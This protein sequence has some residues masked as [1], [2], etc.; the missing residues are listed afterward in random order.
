MN[1]FFGNAQSVL[2]KSY[3]VETLFDKGLV[4]STPAELRGFGFEK[5]AVSEL[6]SYE[7]AKDIGKLLLSNTNIDEVYYDACF[8]ENLNISNSN[9]LTQKVFMEHFMNYPAMNLCNDLGLDKI[10]YYGLSQQGCSGLLGCIELAYRSILCSDNSHT[11]LCITSEKIPKYCFYDRP[12][13]RLLHSDSASGCLVSSEPLPYQILG[14]ASISDTKPEVKMFDLLLQ[15]AS[16]TKKVLQKSSVKTEEIENVFT[17]NF[18]PD[19]WN[20][21]LSLLKLSPET[22]EQD[23]IKESAHAFSSDFIINLTKREQKGLV[24]S[25]KVQLAYGYGYGAHL[26]CLVFQKI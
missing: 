24:N 20:R 11:A 18:W 21:L 16:V 8:S 17:P 4:S 10:K 12:N 6:S 22:F 23:N 25:G 9:Q 3:S 19:F 13:Q 7:M 5:N 26:Y 14:V 15:F 2:G 1:I